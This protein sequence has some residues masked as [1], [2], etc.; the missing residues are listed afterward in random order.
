MGAKLLAQHP[1]AGG[2][3][4]GQAQ[5]GSTDGAGGASRAGSQCHYHTAIK[6]SSLKCLCS[7]RRAPSY[8]KMCLECLQPSLLQGVTDSPAAS[9]G[10]SF[11]LPT[12]EGGHPLPALPFSASRFSKEIPA[13]PEDFTTLFSEYHN[14]FFFN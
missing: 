1:G 11:L 4:W 3:P 5:V 7:C 12:A 10:S 14:I 13:Q 6:P 9:L 8:G 2:E